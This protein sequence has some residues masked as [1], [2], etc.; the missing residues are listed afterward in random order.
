MGTSLPILQRT[1]NQSWRPDLIPTLPSYLL[2][3]GTHFPLLPLKA[4]FDGAKEEEAGGNCE[5]DGLCRDVDT[6]QFARVAAEIDLLEKRDDIDKGGLD[7]QKIQ[8]FRYFLEVSE[9]W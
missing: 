9:I 6:S 2:S 7:W 5:H 3:C 4:K 8:R 1:T